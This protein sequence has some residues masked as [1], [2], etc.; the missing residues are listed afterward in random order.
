MTWLSPLYLGSRA[1][2]R[3]QHRI[4]SGAGPSSSGLNTLLD[5]TLSGT[6]ADIFI[7]GVAPSIC[8]S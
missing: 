2:S 5:R 8:Y 6:I 4:D 3:A 1:E 7:A